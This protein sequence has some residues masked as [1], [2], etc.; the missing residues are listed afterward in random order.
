MI[1]KDNI[2]LICTLYNEADSI[3]SFLDSV[4]EMS[5]IPFEFIIVDGCSTDGTTE[6]IKSYIIDHKLEKFI[7]LIVSAE[8]NIS[9]TPG[10]IAKGRNIAISEAQGSI[11]ACTDAG[12]R[13]EK[14]WLEEITKPLLDDI[15]ID[16]VGGWYLPESKTYFE[17]CVG[18]YFVQSPFTVDERTFLPSSRSIAFRKMVWEKV[19]GYPESSLTG[20]DTK[21]DLE[22]RKNNIRI[23]Y[24]SSA[25]V[26]WRMR[27]SPSSYFKMIR[28]YGYGDGYSSSLLKSFIKSLTKLS[29]QFILISFIPFYSSWFIVPLMVYWLVF[30]FRKQIRIIFD[31]KVLLKLPVLGFLQ[32]ISEIAYITG[33][34]TGKL[35]KVRLLP[36]DRQ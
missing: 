5:S 2:S 31:F 16:V 19:G 9:N 21:F 27:S 18:R 29:I 34:I 12:C 22:L 24:S 36:N 17:E 28:N 20:E 3:K 32:L 26:Y 30:P 4:L 14:R 8:C 1:K 35:L 7:R 6:I 15:N 25:L 33:Y 10:P 11:I 13:P 23:H